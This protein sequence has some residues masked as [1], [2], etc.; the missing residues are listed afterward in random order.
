MLQ[1][2]PR[3]IVGLSL[4]LASAYG[5]TSSHPLLPR[6]RRYPVDPAIASQ[7]APTWRPIF[8]DNFNGSAGTPPSSANWLVYSGPGYG[9]ELETYSSSPSN[10]MLDGHGHLLLIAQKSASGTWTSG[11]VQA[12][13][14]FQATPGESL[15]IQARVELP[16][17][18]AG[19]WPAVWAVAESFKS[20]ANSEPAAGE[21]D[22]AETID[23]DPWVAQFVHC[24]AAAQGTR[25]L[26]HGSFGHA[27]PFL[28]PSGQAGWHVYSWEWVNQGKDPYIQLAVGGTPQLTIYKSQMSASNWNRAFAHPYY[29]IMNLA[30]GGWAGN[31]TTLSKSTASMSI[32]YVKIFR[33]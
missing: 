1:K 30:V 32:D 2:C 22:L 28:T 12:K 5:A 8:T 15:L 3:F 25:C 26:S 23:D 20:D 31:P 24:G 19:Y 21:V 13:F 18:G 6:D 27:H 14:D 4:C 17:G 7:S 11:E 33:S 16:N 29:L 10:I 9:T